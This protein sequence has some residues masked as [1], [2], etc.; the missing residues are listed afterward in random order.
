QLLKA[1]MQDILL[2]QSENTSRALERD[3]KA[4]VVDRLQ[5]IIE[6]LH[7]KGGQRVRVIG[8]QKDD[9][10][11]RPLRQGTQYLYAAHP[12]HLDIEKYQVR[13]ERK[14]RPYRVLA[15]CALSDHRDVGVLRKAKTDTA[16]GQRFVVHDQYPKV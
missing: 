16:A 7:L 3:K 12:R 4:H 1:A 2:L 15:I 9:A 10:G 6:R 13:L 11:D 8:G 14:N 5:Q